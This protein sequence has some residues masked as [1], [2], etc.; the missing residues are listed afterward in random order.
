MTYIKPDPLT[1]EKKC[2]FC[3]GGLEFLLNETMEEEGM[4]FRCIPCGANY[5]VTRRVIIGRPAMTATV[6]QSNPIVVRE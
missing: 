3:D 4:Q 2:F 6:T 1:S 5:L